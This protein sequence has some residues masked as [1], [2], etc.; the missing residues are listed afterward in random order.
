MIA[1]GRAVERKHERI[2]AALEA[3]IRTG[4]VKRGAQLPGEVALARRFQVSRNTVRSALAEL[5]RAGLI[6]TR[7]G[8]GSCSSTAGPLTHDT[9][10]HTPS[11]PRASTRWFEC[12]AWN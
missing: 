11:P 12:S 2:V 5:C 10:G 1:I 3:E 6:A 4:L 8:K 9:A 7:T